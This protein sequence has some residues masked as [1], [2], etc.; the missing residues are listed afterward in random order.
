MTIY[1]KSEQKS[2]F[3]NARE[4]APL[5]SSMN[6]FVNT[7]ASSTSGPLAVAVPGELKGYVEAKEKFGNPDLS[8]MDIMKPTIGKVG[9]WPST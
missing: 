9:Q 7:S 5:K 3:L 1:I 4:V 2:Y 6:M 8:L